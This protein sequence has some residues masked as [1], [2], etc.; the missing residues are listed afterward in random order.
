MS[1]FDFILG[2]RKTKPSKLRDINVPNG[3]FRFIAL[4]VETACMDRA[5]ICQIGIACVKNDNAIETFSMLINPQTGFD[6]FN[7]QLHGIGPEHVQDAPLFPEAMEKMLPLLS[8]H[9]LIQH[10]S[11]DRTAMIAACNFNGLEPPDLQ[12][13]DSVLIARRAWPEFKGKGGHG[14]SSLKEKLDLKFQHHDAGEDARAAAEIVLRAEARLELSFDKILSANSS[15]HYKQVIAKSGNPNGS[16][17]GGTVVFTG[18]LSIQR[19]EAAKLAADAG[20]NV[21]V[22]VG[23]DTTYLVVGDQ[24]Q[25]VLA[26]HTKSTKHRKAEELQN[27]GHPIQ[28]IAESVFRKLIKKSKR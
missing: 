27:A 18:A 1:I 17:T 26:G 5:S 11:F 22:N 16:L 8:R 7:I 23:K 3:E 28:I 6:G 10:S 14:L 12:W 9:H 13:S 19:R 24:D 15:N 25:S 2:R 21:K 20:L 4:D